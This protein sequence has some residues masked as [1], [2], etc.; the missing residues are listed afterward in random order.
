MELVKDFDHGGRYKI[1]K[2]KYGFK[3]MVKVTNGVAGRR[4][5]TLMEDK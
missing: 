2:G 3:A 4:G 5:E 1:R